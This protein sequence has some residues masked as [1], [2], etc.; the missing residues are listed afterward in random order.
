[1]WLR[2][3]KYDIPP[4][5]KIGEVAVIVARL[6]A[7]A[8]RLEAVYDQFQAS[9]DV[10]GLPRVSPINKAAPDKEGKGNA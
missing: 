7:V 2:K 3:K 6:G 5:A 4:P 1:M 9:A 10:A 8:D